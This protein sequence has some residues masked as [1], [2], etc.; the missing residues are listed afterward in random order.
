MTFAGGGTE[1][2]GDF[3]LSLDTTVELQPAKR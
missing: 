1:Q 2:A 3:D